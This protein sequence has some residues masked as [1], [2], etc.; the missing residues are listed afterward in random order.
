MKSRSASRRWTSGRPLPWRRAAISSNS[1]SNS[2]A[3]LP[4]SRSGRAASMRSLNSATSA[5][6]ATS[7]SSW[8]ARVSASRGSN[9]R[10]S[11]PSRSAS[12][13]WGRRE[14]TGTAPPASARSTSCGAG[15]APVEAATAIVA[16][17][18]CW[19]SE[20]SAGP[21]SVTRSRSAP[22]QRH[23][24]RRG[25][26]AQPDRRA[27]VELGREAAQRAQEQPQGTP[28]LLGG[29]DDLR[30]PLVGLRAVEQVGAGPDHPVVAGEV[31][32]DQV[33]RRGEARRAA[34]EAT[35]Q[36]LDDL[37]RHLGR[38]EPLGGR[39][40]RAD[41]ERARVAQGRRR[42]ARGERLVHVHEVEL[43][44]VEQVLERARHVQ[45]Q[46]HRAAAPERER[47]ADGEHRGAARARRRW[48][49]GRCG[50]SAPWPGP[51]GPAHASRKARPRRPGAR[52]CRARRR[53]S[54]RS[55]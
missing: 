38:D 45:R 50:P 46:R 4:Q 27:P 30:R 53:A 1:A 17:A 48:R 3:T 28:L 41:V 23:G 15:A 21:A 24:G 11:S 35:E 33:A 8:A 32:L 29:E 49:R 55:G 5:G 44:V 7:R 54:R 52:A 10:P 19:A 36:Q 13:Y 16:R 39:V 25:R 37:A 22:G 14:T 20:P 43:G 51:L 26:V 34:V 9:S 40:E 6:S 42:R 2:S 31:A 47:L 18:R 12:S